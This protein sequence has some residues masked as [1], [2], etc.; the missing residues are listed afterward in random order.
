MF[1]VVLKDYF[2]SLHELALATDYVTFFGLAKATLSYVLQSIGLAIYYVLSFHWLRDFMELPVAFKH[3]YTLILENG[4]IIK[5][6]PTLAISSGNSVF[7]FLDTSPANRHSL[8]SGFFNSFFLSLPLSVAH[9]LTLRALLVNGTIAGLVSF[10][11]AFCGQFLFYF[12]ML[13]GLEFIMQPLFQLDIVVIGLGCFLT[14][15]TLYRLANFPD[16]TILSVI[17]RKPL[18]GFFR[19]SFILTWFEQVCVCNYF[20]NMNVNPAYS[21][22]ETTNSPHFFFMTMFYFVGLMIGFV[23]WSLGFYFVVV[24]LRSL[25]SE[26]LVNVSF[27]EMNQKIHYGCVI[28]LLAM[29]MSSFFYYGYDFFM[30]KTLGYVAEDE[31]M[32]WVTPSNRYY[33]EIAPFMEDEEV[34]MEEEEEDVIIDGK[35]FQSAD[36]RP[37]LS[38]EIFGIQAENDE[39]NKELNLERIE[40]KTGLFRNPSKLKLPYKE[41]PQYYNNIEPEH[42]IP[43]LTLEDEMTPYAGGSQWTDTNVQLI[44]SAFR[45][46]EYESQRDVSSGTYLP[47]T[48]VYRQFREKYNTNILYR[49][50]MQLNNFSFLSGQPKTSNLS[51][52]DEIS[53]YN[54]RISMQRYL[55]SVHRY[56]RIIRKQSTSFPE[57]V[58]NQQFKGSLN[59]V[60]KFNAVELSEAGQS[61][62]EEFVDMFDQSRMIN[63]GTASKKKV[64]KYDQP[65]YKKNK[66]EQLALLHEE[67]PAKPKHLRPKRFLKPNDTRP[68]YIGWDNS[69]RKFMIKSAIV[70]PSFKTDIIEKNQNDQVGKTSVEIGGIKDAEGKNG[71][72]NTKNTKKEKGKADKTKLKDSKNDTKKTTKKQ[73]KKGVK[74]RY[75]F[76]TSPPKKAPLWKRIL[77]MKQKGQ[78]PLV[79]R[80]ERDVCAK[81]APVKKRPVKTKRS[82]P[83]YLHFQAWSPGIETVDSTTKFKLPSLMATEKD[84]AKIE[85]TLEL[86]PELDE[87]EEFDP[88]SIE[89]KR[90]RQKRANDKNDLKNIFRRTPIYDW[91]WQLLEIPEIE[92]VPAFRFADATHPKIDGIA[93]PGQN[94]R[95]GLTCPSFSADDD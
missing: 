34:D 55:N 29:T 54:R 64:L 3:T 67:L 85:E 89:Q 68:L 35:P 33:V 66:D 39:A 60:R 2:D 77:G 8:F 51:A 49:K 40:E 63:P 73:V 76:L 52:K 31:A 19:L 26:K 18:L 47:E 43:S 42:T 71:T 61:L 53:L 87:D 81:Y 78:Y 27:F 25:L 24:Q 65:L 84:Y 21:M 44:D 91:Y 15:E 41:N 38:F 88:R 83:D 70:G 6:L 36:Q 92:N 37:E 56:K 72:E 74:R 30:T 59:F 16:F 23:V 9:I 75:R 50:L 14:V 5:G 20:G 10:F 7:S 57:K 4:G 46:D 13:F 69:L 45:T 32:S 93:W 28:G 17:D 11:G 62:D 80:F 94:P 90:A 22:F 95:Y 58:Y 82:L 1:S 12:C 86:L 48:Q 79:Y